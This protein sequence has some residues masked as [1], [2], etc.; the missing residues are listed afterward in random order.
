MKS[1]GRNRLIYIAT[2]VAMV[3]AS[4]GFVV[5]TGL[6]ATSTTQNASWYQ[7]ND[8]A[9][10]AFP[11]QPTVQTTTVP[12]GVS[13]CTSSAQALASGGTATLVLGASPSV[14]CKALDFAEEFTLTSTATAGA[15][16]YPMTIYDSYGAGPTTGSAAGTISISAALTVAGTVNIYV[17]FGTALPPAGGI[18]ELDLIVQ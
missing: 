12:S 15:G 8:Q 16:N 17:D 2:A 6:S 18:S 4:M 9:P 7:V 10:G 14:T 11:S 1:S 13:A 5:A 3:S